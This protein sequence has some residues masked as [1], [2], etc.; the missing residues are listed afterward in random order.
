MLPVIKRPALGYPLRASFFSHTGTYARFLRSRVFR[1]APIPHPVL[2][3][4]RSLIPFHPGN[5]SAEVIEGFTAEN[6]LFS[7]YRQN[8]FVGVCSTMSGINARATTVPH[9]SDFS[10]AIANSHAS[11]K[12]FTADRIHARRSQRSCDPIDSR[13]APLDIGRVYRSIANYDDFVAQPNERNRTVADGTTAL[14]HRS[15]IATPAGGNRYAMRQ[16][17][18][19]RQRAEDGERETTGYF[20]RRFPVALVTNRTTI[21]APKTTMTTTKEENKETQTRFVRPRSFSVA[22]RRRIV[23]VCCTIGNILEETKKD[24]ERHERRS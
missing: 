17:R 14:R 4:L 15:F 6:G 11:P 24:D 18:K 13:P 12:S 3:V 2:P 1:R 21:R 23:A 5:I 10:F 20:S 16:R 8:H 9:R 22:R 19:A 7:L